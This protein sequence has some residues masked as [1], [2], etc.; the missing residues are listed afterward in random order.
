MRRL[1]N[2]VRADQ[3]PSHLYVPG[4]WN[5]SHKGTDSPSTSFILVHL[6]F[7]RASTQSSETSEAGSHL[8][9]LSHFT[10]QPLPN[11]H[12]LSFLFVSYS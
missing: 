12:F 4:N 11:R 1:G 8:L 7:S 10:K 5:C 2:S 6:S 3:N 9:Y